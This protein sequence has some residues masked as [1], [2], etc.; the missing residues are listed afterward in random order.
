MQ[1]HEINL[2]LLIGKKVLG[3][4]GKSLGRLEE[5]V[6]EMHGRECLIEE[7]HV[8]GYALFERLSAWTIGRAFLGLLG[9]GRGG[10]RIPWT[11]MDLS[12]PEV[13]RVCCPVTQLQRLP[14]K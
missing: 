5:I 11:E 2:E 9:L 4:S 14:R 13:P 7:F 1:R 6:A 10:Y 8:G 3:V 12:D